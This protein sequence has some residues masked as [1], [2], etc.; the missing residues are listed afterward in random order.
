MSEGKVS[1]SHSV[2][3]C[4]LADVRGLSSIADDFV[5]GGVFPHYDKDMIESWD[6]GVSKGGRLDSGAGRI[7]DRAGGCRWANRRLGLMA[8]TQKHREQDKE[9]YTLYGR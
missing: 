4:Q 7:G 2:L 1:T 8:A 5:G 6:R 3:A 9:N